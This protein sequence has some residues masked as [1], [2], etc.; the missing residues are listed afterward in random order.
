MKFDENG[1]SQLSFRN[2]FLKL[3]HQETNDYLFNDR[4]AEFM[5]GGLK[6]QSSVVTIVGL[7]KVFSRNVYLEFEYI[8]RKFFFPSITYETMN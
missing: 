5:L 7:K 8:S 3:L 6:F 1:K 4:G 2:S